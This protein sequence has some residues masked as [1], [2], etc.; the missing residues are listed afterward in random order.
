MSDSKCEN[1]AAYRYTWP[2]SNERLICESC[3]QKLRAIANAMGLYVQLIEV[4]VD[5]PCQQIKKK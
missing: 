4:D 2:G 3:S 1:V 5:E